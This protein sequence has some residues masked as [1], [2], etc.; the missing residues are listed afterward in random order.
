MI[1]LGV[2]I[3]IARRRLRRLPGFETNRR[4]QRQ[5]P[6]RRPHAAADVGR[7]R[8]D[9]LGRRHQRHAR[10]YRPGVRIRLLGG[11]LPAARACAV[12]V[13]DGRVLRQADEPDGAD[14]VPR[15]L[16]AAVR[17]ARRGRR[18]AD[19]HRRLLPSGGGQPGGGRLSVQLL[20]RHSVLARRGHHRDPR[21]RLHRNGRPDRRRVH[22]DHPD[23][24]GARRRRRPADLDGRHARHRDRGGHG[25]ARPRPDDRSRAGRHHQ[26]GDADRARHRRHRRDRLHAAGVRREVAG[27]G[28]TGLLRRRDRRRRDL[29]PVRHRG[30]LGEGVPA[31]G[32]RR[33]DPVR[34]AG[35]ITRRCS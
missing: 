1:L 35:P 26:L 2:G 8:A 9:G 15:L 25:S 22:R 14:V 16:P 18:I 12:P 32:A 11:R 13:P 34:A 28:A 17:P 30:A 19:A 21:G 31:R 27:D 20:R 24:P 6:R 29:C 23:G 33:A 7:R 4:R 10:Q 5:F 3:S